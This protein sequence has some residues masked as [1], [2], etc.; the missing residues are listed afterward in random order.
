LSERTAII[1]DDEFAETRLGFVCGFGDG[2]ASIIATHANL[3][4]PE[5]GCHFERSEESLEQSA[6]CRRSQ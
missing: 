5:Q 6:N 1:G 3:P 4:Q 2:G